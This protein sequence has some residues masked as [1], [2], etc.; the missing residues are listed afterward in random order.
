MPEVRPA[1]PLA[2][3][4]D[5]ALAELLEAIR[6]GGR[7]AY[8]RLLG[9]LREPKSLEA[10]SAMFKQALAIALVR[11]GLVADA[12]RGEETG[13]CAASRPRR[14]PAWQPRNR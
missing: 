2:L 3:D 11:Q 9:I 13:C 5:P 14:W 1:Q 10:G 8:R 4:P 6:R 7:E 12:I